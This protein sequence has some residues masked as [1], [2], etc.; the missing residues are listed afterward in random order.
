MFLTDAS[1]GLGKHVGNPDTPGKCWYHQ[2]YGAMQAFAYLSVVDLRTDRG[3]SSQEILAFKRADAEAMGQ[4]LLV[5][6]AEGDIEWELELA[7][8]LRD[9][10]VRCTENQELAP[11]KRNVDRA[12]ERRQ[13]LHV[14]YFEG[15]KGKGKLRWELLQDEHARQE[16]RKDSG[17]G[18]SQ[19]AE[20]AY[21]D[22]IGL[23]YLEHDIGTFAEFLAF[24]S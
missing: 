1:S 7:E 3:Q 10:E 18:A 13:V 9:A 17:L 15:R 19:T 6:E 5:R 23:S 8:S 2:I 11:W 16:A 14:F 24:H 22:K 20:V 12:A 21:L 4:R